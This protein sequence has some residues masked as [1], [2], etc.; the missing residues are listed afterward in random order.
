M[1][2]LLLLMAALPLVAGAQ[3]FTLIHGVHTYSSLAGTTVYMSGPSELRVTSATAPLTGCTIHLNSD[4][5]FLV[6]P[7]VRPSAV[8]SNYLGQVR[9]RGVPAV[10]DNNCRVVPYAMG[11]IVLPHG[12]S[13]QPLTVF[14]GPHFTGESNSLGQYTYYTASLGALYADI[15]SFKLRRGYMATFAE[16]EDGTGRSQCYIAQDGDLE[17]SVLP[18]ALDNN[19]RRVLVLPWRWTSKKGT[20]GDPGIHQLNIKWWYNWNLN[21]NSSRDVEYVAIR[22]TRWWPGLDQNWQALGINTVLGY[23][24]PDNTAEANLSVGDALW[25]WPDLLATGLRTGSP[26]TTDGGYSSWLYP[27]IQQADAANLRVDFTAVHYY[28]CFNPADP[29]GAA[30]QMYNVLKAIYDNTKR[31]IWVTEWNNGANWTGCADPTFEQQRQCIEAMMDMLDNTPWVE[32]YAL[33]SWVEE[34]RQTH[35][36]SGGLTPMGAAYRDRQ[37][38]VGYLQALPDNGTRSMAQFL[39]EANALDSSGYGNNGLVAGNPA[40]TTGRR[41]QALV[42]DGTNTVVTLPPNVARGN[43]FTFAAWVQWGGGGNWQRIFDFGN[44]TTHY[45]YLTPNSGSNLRF[46]IKNGGAEQIVQT[47]PLPV[48]SWQHV[49]VTLYGSTARLYTNGVLAAQNNN[50]TI[51]PS[52]FAPRVNYLGKSQFVADPRFKGL[53]DEVIIADTAFSAAQIA[54]L[55]TNRAPLFNRAVVVKSSANM[56]QPYTDTLAGDVM[57]PDGDGALTFSK[58]SGPDWLLV[59]SRGALGGT[60][61]VRDGGTNTF[62]VRV[63]DAAGASAFVTLNIVVQD[64]PR[65]VALYAFDGNTFSKVGTAHGE[66]TGTANY[67]SGRYGQAIDLDGT[68]HYITL[69]AGVANGDDM[70]VA[71]WVNWDGGAAWQRIFDFGTGTSAYLFLTPRSANN[72]MRF[73]IRTPASGGEQRLE[74]TALPTNTWTHVAVVLHGDAGKLFI[75]GT[76]VASNA[77]TLDPSA[78][79]PTLN[80][81]GKSQ[82]TADPLFKGRLDDF[83]IYNRALADFE[84]AN[85]ANPGHDSDADG[86]TDGTEGTGDTDGDNLPDYLDEDS[87]NDGIPDWREGLLDVDRDGLPNFRDTDSDDDGMPDRWEFAYGLRPNDAADAEVDSDGDGQSNRAEYIAGTAP[88]RRED[89]FQLQIETVWPPGMTVKGVT[90]RTYVLWRAE[91]PAGPWLPVVTNGPV[92]AEGPLYFEVPESARRAVFYRMS[93]TWP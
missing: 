28:R 3:V 86:L 91:T 58:V 82:F 90:G 76:L 31:P 55:V 67:V 16:N 18:Q 53:M 78:I 65:M 22:Q 43:A 20:A 24:E 12:P 83:H 5:A 77:I 72:T 39:F 63:V 8:V 38:P 9:V 10:V 23:N 75:N 45:M 41:G 66:L 34:V 51:T 88:D 92:A 79:R 25:S 48:G 7:G 69:P 17:I 85:L 46:A 26:A 11:S 30:N 19:V 74:T 84:I 68:S 73:A 47:T 13:F 42:F 56:D 1:R 33:F 52:D 93:V 70:T 27:F 4:G 35:Y 54:A 40:Y 14:S 80:Y 87:D 57:D 62:V 15:S 37:S 21:A 50:M 29:A 81:L 2:L 36:N 59:A 44:S 61:T 89:V 32:R 60:P 6:L 71:A 49:A 64:P